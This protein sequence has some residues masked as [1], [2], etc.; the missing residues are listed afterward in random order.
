MF[1]RRMIGAGATARRRPVRACK[2]EFESLDTRAVPAIVIPT[3]GSP[4]LESG[5]GTIGSTISNVSFDTSGHA[6]AQTTTINPL[7]GTTSTSA[8]L[9]ASNLVAGA[10]TAVT[11]VTGDG[12]TNPLTLAYHL[13]TPVQDGDVAVYNFQTGQLEK[14]LR[15]QTVSDP[16]AGTQGWLLVYSTNTTTDPS[17]IPTPTNSV[18]TQSAID[19]GVPGYSIVEYGAEQANYSGLDGNAVPFTF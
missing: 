17:G 18:L 4:L 8:K 16:V 9:L 10:P 7:T 14:L 12:S 6:I 3:P 1:L 5:L 11:G 13:P 19:F 15:F 2:L